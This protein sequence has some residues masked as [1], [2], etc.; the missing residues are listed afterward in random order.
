[1]TKFSILIVFLLQFLNENV[2]SQQNTKFCN[3]CTE[4]YKQF[5]FWLGD[6]KVYNQKGEKIG[7]NSIV[8]MQD[9]CVIQENWSSVGQTGTSC[10][11]Y[12]KKDSSWDQIYIDNL[13]TV[14]QLKGSFQNNKIILKS[15][16]IKNKKAN[17]YYFNRIAWEKIT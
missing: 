12:N 5:D 11:F 13:G 3:C 14:L 9:S 7:S 17:F 16:Q 2:Y 15:E 10:T 8:S 1:M 4:E 6:W